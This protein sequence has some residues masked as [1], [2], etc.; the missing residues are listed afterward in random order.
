MAIQLLL[1]PIAPHLSKSL[2]QIRK[3]IGFSMVLTG[4]A[5]LPILAHAG[6]AARFGTHVST[7]AAINVTGKVT[8][9]KGEGLPGVSIMIKGTQTGTLTDAE[10]KYSLEVADGKAVLLFSYVGYKPSEV[11]LNERSIVDV[12]LESDSKA[13]DELVVVGYGTA[14]KSDLTGSVARISANTFK[15]QSVTQLTDVLAGTVAGF[16]ANQGTSAAG[17]SSMEIR[18][19]NSLNAATSPM[20]ILDGVIFNGELRDINSSDIETMDIL[21]DASSSAIYGA[22]AA[23]GV[24]LITTT[25]GKSGKPTINFSTKLGI[26]EALNKNFGARGPQGYLDFRRD[27]FRTLGQT[28]PDFYWFNPNQLP[29]GVTLDQWRAAANNP[30]ADNTREWLARLNF[31][32]TEIESYV[33]GQP[34]DWANEFFQKG[35][36]QEYDLSIGGG[37]DNVS[38]YWSLGYLDNTGII[39]GDKFSAIR[40]RLNV[41]FKVTNWLNTGINAQ[42]TNRDESAVPANI[43]GLYTVSPYARIY[44]TDGTMAWFPHGYPGGENPLI[45]PYG[46]DRSKVVNSV[47]ASIYAELKLPL[48]ITYRISY[49]PRIE[50]FRDLNFWSPLTLVGGNARSGGYATRQNK[51]TSEWMVDNLLKWNKKVGIH[52]FDVTLLY[53]AERFKSWDETN[54][55]EAFAPS[56]VLGYHGMQ[57]G[58]KP[59]LTS[60]DLRY[61]G[62]GLMGRINYSLMDKYL[63]TASVRRD[64][65]SA[66][67]QENP[68]AIFPAA[69]FAWKISNE[70]FF[71]S[72]KI[73][74]MKLRVS[75]GKNG[76][77]DIGPYAAFSQMNSVQ[78]YNGS[79]TQIG[80]FT[81]T[82]SNPS[83][84]WEETESLNAGIDLGLFGN[85]VTVTMDAYDATTRNLLVRRSLPRVTGFEYVT[86]NIGALGNRGFEF[87][88]GST[89]VRNSNITWRSN[90]NFSLNRNRIKTLFG[91]T[92]S[93]TLEGRQQQGEVPDFS[94]GW[95][96]GQP[97]DVVWNYDIQGTWQVE[98]AEQ[99]KRYNL[100][101]GDL[102]AAD[103]DDN[104]AYEALQDK[105]FIGYS[106]PRFNVGFRNEVE[107][108]KNFTASIFLRAD[109][110]H[111]RDFRESVTGWSTFDRNSTANYPY[112]TPDNRNNEFPRLN[113]NV[114]PFGGGIMPYKSVSFLRVQDVSLSY[115]VPSAIASIAKF[116]SVRVFAAVRNLATFTKWPGWDPETSLDRTRPSLDP[117]PRTFTFGLNVSL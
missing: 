35:K 63:L 92:G 54:T 3:V 10:G 80:V 95:F 115:N 73:N 60:N 9:E 39:L 4:A 62:D 66:F 58:G 91:Q 98:E 37:T 111:I 88:L 50:T 38:Y 106:E 103:L 70:K 48:G 100:K 24:I 53:N 19:S 20:I 71:K 12:Q 16:Q 2:K 41:D 57:F 109:L 81:S 77:R 65:F 94:N 31:F 96:I 18:G 27:F 6:P 56:Y 90:V 5:C 40:S 69:A 83:L 89:N 97:I 87:T 85:R 26:S 86:T 34:V 102:K 13:L 44:N 101:P 36:R 8:D 116:N 105:K 17:G 79:A 29:Q 7:R 46:Q 49:Q 108:L 107:F 113:N 51:T 33:A 84:K 75:W 117:M 15:S 99:A 52:S 93:Y 68:R 82:L 25:K 47:F 1:N 11:M 67:G 112:W 28:Q 59:T 64:G 114:A 74:E 32:P 22:R 104:G 110:G 30:N 61:S 23:N 21:K 14:K 78:Y 55:N 43:N 42:Y 45:N 76:N 72:E